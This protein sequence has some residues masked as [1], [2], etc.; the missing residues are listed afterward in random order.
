M[1]V[2]LVTRLT[3]EHVSSKAANLK[4]NGFRQSRF[5]EPKH[6]V[7]EIQMSNSKRRGKKKKEKRKNKNNK[8]LYFGIIRSRG[9]H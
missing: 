3:G 8:D 6:A 4:L 7:M 2:Q 5:T 1:T 9:I